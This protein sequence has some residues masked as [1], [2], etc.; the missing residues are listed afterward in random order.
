MSKSKLSKQQEKLKKLFAKENPKHV[1]DM[2]LKFGNDTKAI[3]GIINAFEANKRFNKEVSHNNS[4]C[5]KS[6]KRK[7]KHKK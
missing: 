6:I 7:N 2:M 3:D 4:K 5:K 1:H